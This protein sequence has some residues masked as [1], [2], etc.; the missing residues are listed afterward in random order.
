[1]VTTLFSLCITLMFIFIYNRTYAIGRGDIILSVNGY[2]TTGAKSKDVRRMLKNAGSSV[3]MQ[4]LYKTR[5]MCA[6]H[7]IL[8]YIVNY[9]GKGTLSNIYI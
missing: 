8:L 1:M 4:L 3:N 9:K 2:S 6:Y 7:E 5:E